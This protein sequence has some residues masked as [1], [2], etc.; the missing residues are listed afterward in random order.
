LQAVLVPRK[1]C[2]AHATI[3]PTLERLVS[4][5]GD[6]GSGQV[7]RNVVFRGLTFAHAEWTM[8]PKGYFDMRAAVPAPSAIDAVD[9]AIERDP[10]GCQ[11]ALPWGKNLASPIDA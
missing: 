4:L 7:V 2:N 3:A 1:K 10:D 8:D 6:P 9:V 11:A 5:E